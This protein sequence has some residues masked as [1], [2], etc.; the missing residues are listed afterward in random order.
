MKLYLLLDRVFPR[1]FTAKVFFLAF[2]GTH[3]PLICLVAY[4]LMAN[5]GLAAH[6]DVLALVLGATLAGTAGTLFLLY[7]ILSPLYRIE[8][9]MQRFESDGQILPLP[10]HT[11][12][13]V[14]RLM[15]RTMR[16]MARVSDRLAQAQASADTD[17]LTGALNRRGFSRKVEEASPGAVVHLDLDHFK[18]IN[19]THGHDAGDRLLCNLTSVLRANLRPRD[20]LARFGGEEFLVFLPG[21]GREEALEVAERLR[22]AVERACRV[23]DQVVTASLGVSAGAD[24]LGE[25]IKRADAATYVSKEQGRNRVVFHDP[26]AARRPVAAA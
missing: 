23:E 13:Q 17:P 14:G 24:A 20:V 4:V 9:S 3:V 19:D 12:D 21:A 1:S 25:R 10:E 26:P 11:R 5:G 18:A 2:M 16:L 7:C 22:G 6:L 15:Q 8:Q